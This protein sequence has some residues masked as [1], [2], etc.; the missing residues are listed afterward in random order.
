MTR[1]DD[2][3]DDIE[4]GA[5]LRRELVDPLDEG[6]LQR[7]RAYRLKRVQRA[8]S[9]EGLGAAVQT[10]YSLATRD[11][12]SEILPACRELGIGFVA[13][14]PFSRGLLTGKI[15]SLDELGEKDRRRDMLRFQGDNLATNLEMV[16]E[17]TE[18][19]A[20]KD[21]SIASIALAWVLSRGNDVVPIPGCSRR[22]TLN[23]C[24][25][26][27]RV[28][29]SEDELDR[30]GGIVNAGRIVGTRYPEKQ[31]RRLGI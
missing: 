21:C 19:A 3:G 1:L 12:E 27:L 6:A 25:A 24:L 2:T 17:L 5:A 4:R 22:Q 30:I 26:A 8:L 15:A 18:I 29:L 20:S 7:M 13:Y 9:T 31:M 16:N 23:D 14:A 11:V 28:G 10:E